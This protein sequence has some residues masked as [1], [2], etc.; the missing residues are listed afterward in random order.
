MSRGSRLLVYWGPAI[1]YM[2][3]IFYLSSGP[4]DLA[5]PLREVPDY[6]LHTIEYSVLYLLMFR[7]NHQGFQPSSQNGGFFLSTV[8]TVSYGISDEYHQSFV[9]GREA[10]VRDVLAD[11]AGALVG[12]LLIL[13]THRVVALV[14]T[15]GRV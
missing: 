1:I 7:A 14:R 2:A 6:F 3:L 4:V 11:G 15:K 12:I 5:P 8:I 9:P 10:S 13:L